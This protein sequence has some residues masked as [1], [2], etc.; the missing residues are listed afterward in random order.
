MQQEQND[1][2]KL[3]VSMIVVIT[4][5]HHSRPTFKSISIQSESDLFGDGTEEREREAII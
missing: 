3:A 1:H 4:N 5:T 2:T